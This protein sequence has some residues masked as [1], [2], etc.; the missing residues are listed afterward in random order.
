MLWQIN[1]HTNT[2]LHNTHNNW[3]N[4]EAAC[5][6]LFVLVLLLFV[7]S[8]MESSPQVEEVAILIPPSTLSF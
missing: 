8:L 3:T 4:T 6:L 7:S 5:Q 2:H 1:T